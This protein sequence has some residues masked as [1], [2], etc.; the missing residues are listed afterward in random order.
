MSIGSLGLGEFFGP[1]SEVA[2]RM[3][4]RR[5]TSELRAFSWWNARLIIITWGCAL[6]LHRLT[7]W[8]TT[9]S[10]KLSGAI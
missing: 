5:R 3:P 8:R 7:T 6:A 2:L 9:V 10:Q 4:F 1:L